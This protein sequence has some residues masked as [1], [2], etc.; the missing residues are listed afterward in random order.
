[1]ASSANKA[2]LPYSRRSVVAWYSCHGGWIN[3]FIFETSSNSHNLGEKRRKK[4]GGE[5]ERF[6]SNFRLFFRLFILKPVQTKKLQTVLQTFLQTLLQTRYYLS[7]N[8]VVSPKNWFETSIRSRS[9][10]SKWNDLV[11][12]PACSS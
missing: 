8:Y 10:T 6:A 12:V 7:L 9:S 4:K 11:R 2:G 5:T 3:D 1:V